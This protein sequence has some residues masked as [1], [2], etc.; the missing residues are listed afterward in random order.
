MCQFGPP[1][2]AQA[3]CNGRSSTVASDLLFHQFAQAPWKGKALRLVCA[4]TF[5][6]FVQVFKEALWF[7]VDAFLPEGRW[8]LGVRLV[9]KMWACAG[10]T[11]AGLSQERSR[12]AMLSETCTNFGLRGSRRSP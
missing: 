7:E 5:I 10:G 9:S 6:R 12:L 4:R 11:S 1:C 2:A 3:P 8:G